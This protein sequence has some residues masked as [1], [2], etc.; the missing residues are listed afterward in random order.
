MFLQIS[1]GD[2]LL[3]TILASIVVSED[4]SITKPVLLNHHSITSLRQ[5][6]ISIFIRSLDFRDLGSGLFHASPMHTLFLKAT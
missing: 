4:L 3:A 2:A 1:F 5:F 6:T